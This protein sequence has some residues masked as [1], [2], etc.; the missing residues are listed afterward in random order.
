MNGDQAHI[1]NH[2]HNYHKLLCCI[3]VFIMASPY[4]TQISFN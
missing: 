2:V 3:L 1:V 4:K